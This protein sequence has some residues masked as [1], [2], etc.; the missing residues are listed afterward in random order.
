MSK[1]GN[2][3]IIGAFVAGA[4]FLII[5]SVFVFSHEAFFSKNQQF[6]VVFTE[7]INGLNIGAPIK[8]YGVQIG[9]VVKIDVERDQQAGKTLIPVVF[10]VN[11]QH[12]NGYIDTSVSDWE[13]AEV[14][15]LINSG[16]RM[17]LQ[18]GSLLTGQLF[19]EALFLPDIPKVL[20][21]SQSD[22]KE[23]PSIPSSSAEI[24]KTLRKVLASTKSIDIAKVV[25]NLQSTLSHIEQIVGS[26]QTQ[27]TLTAL[28]SSMLGLDRM[29][30]SFDQET[31]GISKDLRDVIQ[32][33]DQL[34]VNINAQVDTL[35]TEAHQ[36]VASGENSLK[37]VDGSLAKV[38]TTLS[39]VDTI[40]NHKSPINQGL[41]TALKEL[42]RAARSARLMMDYLERHPN[43][44]IYGKD[45][46]SGVRQ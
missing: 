26:E 38:D 46:E 19:I 16:L 9:H 12:I 31:H 40:L 30:N 27:S 22:L 29:I 1:Q 41:Q 5:A 15:K 20:Y 21:H 37:K 2:P 6:V 17:Q 13:E 11:P 43:A 14:E 24:Q 3:T 45:V 33:A 28:N 4:L 18:L 10:E 34:I 7:S 8:L 23:I 44:L 36:L 42:T 35:V 32:H 25:N 39:Q